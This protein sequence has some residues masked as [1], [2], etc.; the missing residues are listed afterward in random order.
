MLLL[1][2][3]APMLALLNQTVLGCPASFVS[4]GLIPAL[5]CGVDSLVVGL[6]ALLLAILAGLGVVLI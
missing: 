6:G 5:L 2:L 4:S 3:L 1:Q